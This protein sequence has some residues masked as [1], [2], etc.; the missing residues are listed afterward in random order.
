MGKPGSVQ[1]GLISIQRGIAGETE[2]YLRGFE[3][4]SNI[5]DGY[6]STVGFFPSKIYAIVLKYT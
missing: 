2:E 4:E 6:A 5:G 1:K 3:R